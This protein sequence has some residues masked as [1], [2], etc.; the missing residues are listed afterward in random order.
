[1][2]GTTGSDAKKFVTG[3]GGLLKFDEPGPVGFGKF[4]PNILLIVH[5]GAV[6][7]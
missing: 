5:L 7:E 3:D 2:P 1:V 6:M 4:T